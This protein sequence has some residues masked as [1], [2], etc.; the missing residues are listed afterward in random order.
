M[1]DPQPPMPAA[2]YPQQSGQYKPQPAHGSNSNPN[3]K[4]KKS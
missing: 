1:P 4:T 2:E 3:T